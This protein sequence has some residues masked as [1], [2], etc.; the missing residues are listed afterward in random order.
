[1]ACKSSC[2]LCE[3]LVVSQ[4]VTVSGTN[5]VINIPAG[6]YADNGKYCIIVAQ[7]IPAAATINMPVVI[8]IGTGT[9]LYPLMSCDCTQATACQIGSRTRYATR[10]ET[11]STGGVFRLLGKTCCVNRNLRSINGTAPTATATGTTSA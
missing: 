11:T 5:L 4:S 7:S 1:M 10:V 9:V 2:R 8:T 3:R 6:C